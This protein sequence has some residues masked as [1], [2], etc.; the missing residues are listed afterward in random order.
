MVNM[1]LIFHEHVAYNLNDK[2]LKNY[3]SGINDLEAGR[4]CTSLM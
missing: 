4:L 3:K 1:K 2:R